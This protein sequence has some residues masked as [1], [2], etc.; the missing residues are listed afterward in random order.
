MNFRKHSID[1]RHDVIIPKAQNPITVTLKTR[2][3]LAIT[4]NIQAV[5][6]AIHFN[7][8]ARAVVCKIGDVTPDV[9]LASEMSV[10]RFEPP[11]QMPP[12]FSFGL[13]RRS[14]HST[15]K[16]FVSRRRN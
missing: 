12:E 1:I 15:R 2:R 5:L 3:A 7:N 4:Y 11:A 13:C 6:A 10:W 14:S 9:D 8:Q 16:Y